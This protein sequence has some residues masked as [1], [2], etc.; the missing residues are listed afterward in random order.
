MAEE[1]KK[2][3]FTRLPVRIRVLAVVCLLLMLGGTVFLFWQYARYAMKMHL[4]AGIL[5]AV[6]TVLV[7]LLLF[8]RKHDKHTRSIFLSGMMLTVVAIMVTSLVPWSQV[9]KDPAAYEKHMRYMMDRR[10]M[11]SFFPKDLPD[12]VYEY[13]LRFS[14]PTFRSGSSAYV[15]FRCAGQSISEYRKMARKMSILSP[16]QLDEARAADFDAKYLAQIADFFGT[17]SSELGN[18]KLKI[19]FPEDIDKHPNVRIYIMS[20]EYDIDHP[21][22]EAIL[23]DVANGWVCFTKL[24]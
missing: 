6:C 13:E 11:T 17:D 15:E 1:E 2:G 5:T 24:F 7:G 23:I 18:Y 10:Y 4:C 12:E 14:A 9:S 19:A 21:Q 3:N 8:L 16:M 20:C 22:T